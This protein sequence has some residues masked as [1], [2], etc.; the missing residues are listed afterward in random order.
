V[1]RPRVFVSY[2][3]RTDADRARSKAVCDALEAAGFEPLRD[4]ERLD[5]RLPWKQQIHEMIADAHGAVSLLS[6]PA[7][8]S[9]WVAREAALLVHRW[10]TSEAFGLAVLR[11]SDVPS[12][13][14]KAGKL[15][16][17]GIDE[18]QSVKGVDAAAI[19]AL[20]ANLDDVLAAW[21]TR[22]DDLRTED[23]IFA[24]LR[25]C[26]GE[27]LLR[28]AREL[29]LD[30][31]EI[32]GQG[33]LAH[34]VARAV[35]GKILETDVESVVPALQELAAELEMGQALDVIQRVAPTWVPLAAADRLRTATLQAPGAQAMGISAREALTG[36]HYARRASRGEARWRILTAIPGRGE[37][38][39]HKRRKIF[40]SFEPVFGTA[41][42][43]SL[44][45]LIRRALEKSKNTFVC[46]VVGWVPDTIL[47]D[48]RRDLRPA[49]FLVLTEGRVPGDA[50]WDA[51]LLEFLPPPLDE[52]DELDQLDACRLASALIK[53]TYREERG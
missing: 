8:E 10:R 39:D 45:R 18:A 51:D 34:I 19:D 2:T 23:E 43:A 49:Q 32:S 46:I 40:E 30:V 27:L 5:A 4:R 35:A 21:K 25:D 13:A 1:S 9:D 33:R 17:T 7:L 29:G 52:E 26:A 20:V 48:L 11:T 24:I 12:A 28:G 31:R 42:P 36:E 16:G 6:P 37:D 38:D 3:G 50:D 22:A 41:D 44:Q 53:D 47:E 14:L 15:A